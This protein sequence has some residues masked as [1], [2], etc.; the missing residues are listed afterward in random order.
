MKIKVDDVYT[1]NPVT[2][3]PETS[4]PDARKLMEEHDIR[5]LPVVQDGKLVGIVTLTD[6]LR[7]A[8]SPATS[9][10]IWELNYLL[11][12][13]KVAELMTRDVVTA[14]PDTDLQ[15]VAKIMAERKI[16]GIPVVEGDKVIGIITES[17]VFRAL[18]KLLEEKQDA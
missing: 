6:L 17:D 7:A 18:V 14:T 2:V 5:R 1:R 10:S 15:A 16:G 4:A 3:G 9:L 8:P 13:I 12:K 11:D